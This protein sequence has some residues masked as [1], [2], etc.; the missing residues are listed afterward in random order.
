MMVLWEGDIPL[1]SLYIPRV[2]D[3][4][5]IVYKYLGQEVKVHLIGVDAAERQQLGIWKKPNI[6]VS[7]KGYTANTG[8][9]AD[10]PVHKFSPC[11]LPGYGRAQ[12]RAILK[13]GPLTKAEFMQTAVDL[14]KKYKSRADRGFFLV[15]FFD[16]TSCLEE[17]DGTGLLR[18]LDWPHWLCRITV[19]T[20]T[21]GKIYARTFKL[22]VDMNT[23]QERTDVLKK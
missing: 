21:T 5:A 15:Q 18:D 17:W 19:D 16:D 6:K 9:Q 1:E 4:D 12:I 14:C 2:I 7:K 8:K 13:P 20:D 10:L 23:G 22:A 11:F 3:G